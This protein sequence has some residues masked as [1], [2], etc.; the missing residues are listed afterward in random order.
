MRLLKLHKYRHDAQAS[1]YFPAFTDSLARASGLYWLASRVRLTCI[2]P[3]KILKIALRVQLQNMRLGLVLRSSNFKLHRKL[4]TLSHESNIPEELSRYSR[5]IR[6]PELGVAGQQRLSVTTALLVGCGALGSMIAT[7]LCRAGVGTM[8][9]V[10][11]DFLEVSNLQRQFLFTEKDVESG[12]PKAIAAK[13][14]LNEINSNVNVEAFVED[15]D[16]QNIQQLTDGVDVIVDGTDNFETRFL[17]NDVAISENVPWV[18]GG[19]LGA[20]GQS[21][22]IVPGTSACLNC[23]MLDGPPPPGTSDTCDS[24]GVL[25]PVIGAIASI[26]SMEAIKILS[27]NI[28][29][30][31]KNLTVVGMWSNQFRTMDVSTLRDKVDC[32][33]CKGNDYQWLSGRRGSQTVIMCGRN[34][35][36]LSFAERKPID[37]SAL[38]DRLRPLGRV[39]QNPFLIRFH[40]DD[41]SITAF[42]DGRAII[43]GTEEI[44]VAKKLY[45]QYLGA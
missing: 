37:L 10:D 34:A 21:M 35:V 16:S 4:E 43:S 17:I 42:A 6:F 11:R 12:L 8:R 27:G 20:D 45:A 40:V 24:F 3:N 39:E 44:A 30:V 9:I 25:G 29:A 5:Q 28:Q 23:L 2:F 33:T 41:Y 36:Q 19:C 1:E 38:A 32:P 7:T 13:Q 15:V 14:R 26:Q 18:Y 31:S 22:T